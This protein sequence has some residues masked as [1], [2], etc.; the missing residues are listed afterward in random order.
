MGSEAGKCM[1]EIRKKVKKL[2]HGR[3]HF[4]CE[5]ERKAICWGPWRRLEKRLRRAEKGWNGCLNTSPKQ[6]FWHRWGP[7][8]GCHAI[9]QSSGVAFSG[10]VKTAGLPTLM[11]WTFVGILVHDWETKG[12]HEK[13]VV[14]ALTDCRIWARWRRNWEDQLVARKIESSRTWKGQWDWRVI[15]EEKRR[16]KEEITVLEPENRCRNSSLHMRAELA[17]NQVWGQPRM[18]MVRS[19]SENKHH[20]NIPFCRIPTFPNILIKS[21][22]L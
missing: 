22:N 10:R 6:N 1:A 8:R 17:G 19:K 15:Q 7:V 2:L 9:S 5:V 3:L 20:Q 12:Y 14:R 21:Y 11:K 18:W 4:F 13:T 16:N